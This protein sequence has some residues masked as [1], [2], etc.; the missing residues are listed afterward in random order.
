M[1]LAS[2]AWM[3]GIVPWN[4]MV[5]LVLTRELLN[6]LTSASICISECT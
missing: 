3:N 1:V 4:V 2:D 6:L 5:I